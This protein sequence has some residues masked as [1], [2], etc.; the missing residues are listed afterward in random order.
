MDLSLILRK[1]QLF[2]RAIYVHCSLIILL[3][4]PLR[5]ILLH[6]TMLPIGSCSSSFASLFCHFSTFKVNTSSCPPKLIL[7]VPGIIKVKC[8]GFNLFAVFQIQILLYHS[9]TYEN[10]IQ[11][12]NLTQSQESPEVDQIDGTLLKSLNF[13]DHVLTKFECE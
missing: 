9:N 5:R 10:Q 2:Q 1:L 7:Y 6:P 3:L 11:I 12:Q 4:A 13:T 8:Q